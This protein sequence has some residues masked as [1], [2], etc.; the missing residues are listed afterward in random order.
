M[1]THTHATCF[2]LMYLA[3]I[4]LQDYDFKFYRVAAEKEASASLVDARVISKDVAGFVFF[5][6]K[7]LNKQKKKNPLGA[8]F[9]WTDQ[10]TK[11]QK[12]ALL[13]K[14]MLPLHKL[15]LARV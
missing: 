12:L 1:S 10:K 8:I 4:M 2:S 7:K 14:K 11:K 5:K 13:V 9:S 15:A 3:A 6:G